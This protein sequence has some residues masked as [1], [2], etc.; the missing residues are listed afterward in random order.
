MKRK[1]VAG[2]GQVRH[3]RHVASFLLSLLLATTYVTLKHTHTINGGLPWGRANLYVS[4]ERLL[5]I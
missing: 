2:V 1:Y 4:H 3:S 5:V